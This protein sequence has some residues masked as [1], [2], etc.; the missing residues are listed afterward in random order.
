M[1]IRYYITPYDPASWRD[2]D[3][4]PTTRGQSDLNIKVSDFNKQLRQRWH[5]S[6]TFPMRSW[7]FVYP[8][9]Q[10]ISGSFTGE[11]NQIVALEVGRGFNEFVHWYRS[12]IPSKYPLFLFLEGKWESLELNSSTTLEDIAHFTGL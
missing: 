11:G 1:T 4:D 7:Q 3:A 8:D 6:E 5:L 2:P 10:E 9:G 12:Y